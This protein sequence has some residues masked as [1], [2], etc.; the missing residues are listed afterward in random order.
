MGKDRGRSDLRFFDTGESGLLIQWQERIHPSIYR[1]VRGVYLVL[2]RE[3]WPGILELIP[4]YNSLLVE[5]DPLLL[6]REE[7]VEEILSLY[8]KLEEI[9]VPTPLLY[10]LPT[11]YGGEFGPDLSWLAN[12]TGFTPNEVISMH[13]GRDYLI[14]MLGFSPGFS[15]LGGMDPRLAVP[16][17]R[18]PRARIPAGSVAIASQQTGIY[19]SPTP[20]GWRIIGQTP[21]RLFNLEREDPFLLKAG[22][23][24]RFLPIQEEEYR[25]IALEE[26]RGEYSIEVIEAKEESL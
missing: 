6:N 19:P 16:R 13:A 4:A 7:L 3:R 1:E 25:E 10:L 26:K 2:E 23:L 8:N 5:Y 20:G 22:N 9:S 12:Y 21:L 17:R 11:C 18:E 14:Y 15:Y 24:L